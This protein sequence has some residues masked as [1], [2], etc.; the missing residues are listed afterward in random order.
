VFFRS[1]VLLWTT[2]A[3]DLAVF[4]MDLRELHTGLSAVDLAVRKALS[5]VKGFPLKRSIAMT[6]QYEGGVVMA[7]AVTTT[8]DDFKTV[9]LPREALA[10]PAGYR[11]QEP[12][13]GTPGR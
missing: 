3:I 5:G 9:E 1:T 4:P 7:D 11:Y 12:V 10:V 6:R 2:E 13:I 8:F